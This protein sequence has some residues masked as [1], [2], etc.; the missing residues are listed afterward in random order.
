MR[1]LFFLRF[2]PLVIDWFH[3]L[4]FQL[5]HRFPLASFSR[6]S[7]ITAGALSLDNDLLPFAVF[8]DRFLDNI[9]PSSF[10]QFPRRSIKDFSPG[11]FAFH[12]GRPFPLPFF[13][14]PFPFPVDP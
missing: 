12:S 7:K 3:A 2:P 5:G 13:S 6:R 10:P 4:F 11:V 1:R 8:D 14:V 9:F